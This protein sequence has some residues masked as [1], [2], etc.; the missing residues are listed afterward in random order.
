MGFPEVDWIMTGPNRKG[1]PKNDSTFSVE[2]TPPP[3]MVIDLAAVAGFWLHKAP[4]EAAKVIV[5]GE[6]WGLRIVRPEIKLELAA[7]GINKRGDEAKIAGSRAG[8]SISC[9]M[10]LA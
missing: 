8:S 9:R 7:E 1:A 6:D 5:A 4:S 2:N 10:R 3:G